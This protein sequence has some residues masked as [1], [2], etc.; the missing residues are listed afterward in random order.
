MSLVSTLKLP[1]WFCIGELVATCVVDFGIV[2]CNDGALGCAS[3]CSRSVDVDFTEKLIK[4]FFGECLVYFP[5]CVRRFR[6]PI[7]V[8]CPEFDDLHAVTSR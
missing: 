7:Q 1:V 8:P 2:V 3:C 6:S 4:G 5:T